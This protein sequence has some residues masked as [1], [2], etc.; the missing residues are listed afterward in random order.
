M[1]VSQLILCCL[2]GFASASGSSLMEALKRMKRRGHSFLGGLDQQIGRPRAPLDSNK[3][4]E[5]PIVLVLQGNVEK[6]IPHLREGPCRSGQFG[7]KPSDL[8]QGLERGAAQTHWPSVPRHA[9]DFQGDPFVG[10]SKSPIFPF[11]NAPQGQPS[12]QG[13]P[14]HGYRPDSQMYDWGNAVSRDIPMNDPSSTQSI[15]GPPRMGTVDQS[16][17]FN[18][19][20]ERI[21]QRI[22]KM[23]GGKG[24]RQPKQT[25][26][27][28]ICNCNCHCHHDVAPRQEHKVPTPPPQ[29]AIKKRSHN[30]LKAKLVQK[31]NELKHKLDLVNGLKWVRD[32]LKGGKQ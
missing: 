20:L 3:P 23:L 18:Y 15:Q 4:G 32:T 10:H 31:R 8:G 26:D 17:V 30:L 2:L 9:P 6:N 7:C 5:N 28:H 25:K 14:A 19:A 13:H 12:Q 24:Q 29:K 11:A 16:S 1:Q 22:S 27:T 21:V